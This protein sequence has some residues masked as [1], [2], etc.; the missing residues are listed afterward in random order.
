MSEKCKH[1]YVHA[2]F[3]ASGGVS[4]IICSFC[5]AAAIF[6]DAVCDKDNF[7]VNTDAAMI[8]LGKTFRKAA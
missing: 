6:D 8:D 4:G 5:G 7:I 3:D 2:V 1:T